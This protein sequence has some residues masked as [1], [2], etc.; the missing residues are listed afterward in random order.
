MALGTTLE[1]YVPFYK[2]VHAHVPFMAYSRASIRILSPALVGFFMLCAY[3]VRRMCLRGR[4][5]QCAVWLLCLATLA[6]YHTKRP[7]GVSL[8][9]GMD[10]VYEEVRD[11]AAGKRLL[12]LPLWPGDSAWS[13]I[14]EYYATLT[15][16]PIVNGYNPAPQLAYVDKVYTP[17]RTLNLG[18][19]R[20]GQYETLRG[21][22]VPY[23]VLHQDL[24]PR[25]IS[26]F[27]FRFTVLNLLDSLYL[28]FTRR[29]GPH[30][31]FRVRE[32]PAGPEP[33]FSRRSPVGV[34]YPAQNMKRDIGDVI[35][36]EKASSGRCLCTLRGGSGFLMRGGT[37]LFPTGEFRA[38][39]R[40]RLSA[41][42]RKDARAWIEV[43]ALEQDRVLASRELALSDFP[44]PAEYG[45]FEIAFRN[46][47]PVRVEPRVRH[48]GVGELRADFAYVR[49]AGEEDPGVSY[50]AEDLFHIGTCVEDRSASGGQAV[51]I[52]KNEDLHAPLVE[53]PYRLYGPGR[54][55]ARFS[56]RAER[57]EPGVVAGPEVASGFGG[58]LVRL[59]VTDEEFRGQSS[60]TAIDLPFELKKPVPLSFLLRH[61]NKAFLWLDKIDVERVRD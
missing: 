55:R 3:G 22:D 47:E 21:W 43:Y 17:L 19:M 52:G 11:R 12:E 2:W 8:L 26:P 57:A 15:C 31:L 30:Y 34:L 45:L 50:E 32:K 49:F 40:L 18:E 1:A 14:Y 37:R 24:F 35:H 51:A 56:M 42:E 53:G 54:Y 10:S 39:F 13:A 48:N 6:D 46:D 23:I 36:D 4:A 60:Y 44:G 61:Y 9:R 58:S 16:V 41:P 38:A 25:R 5:A 27:P 28:E 59:D 33:T 7:I 20:R 29:D